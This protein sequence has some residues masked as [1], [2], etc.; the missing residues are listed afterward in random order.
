N[1]LSLGLNYTQKTSPKLPQSNITKEEIAAIDSLKKDKTITILP[2]DKGRTMVVMD[3]K[4]Y[5]SSIETMLKKNKTLKDLLKPPLESK[6]IMQE[7]FNH[8][9][10]TAS[11]ISRIYGTPETHKKDPLQPIVDSTLSVLCFSQR[12]PVFLHVIF[13]SFGSLVGGGCV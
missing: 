3:T 6:K 8:L 12:D 2:A 9:I 7:A 1:V 4:K 11:I 5:T 13:I 10:S